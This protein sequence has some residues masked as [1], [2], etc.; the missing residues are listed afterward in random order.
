V[1]QHIKGLGLFRHVGGSIAKAPSLSAAEPQPN[2]E[3]LLLL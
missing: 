2:D 1:L 3:T